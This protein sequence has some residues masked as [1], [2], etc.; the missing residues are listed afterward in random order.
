MSHIKLSYLRYF[1]DTYW[2]QMGDEVH[3]TVEGAAIAFTAESKDYRF[4]LIS[5]LKEA[6]KRGF[7][8]DDFRD[9]VYNSIYWSQFQRCINNA[10]AA[11]I[12]KVIERY[13]SGSS[14]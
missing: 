6:S 2:N 10:D 12:R 9:P 11:V 5:D 14:G 3:G 13:E 4:G 1:L 8:G 7:L